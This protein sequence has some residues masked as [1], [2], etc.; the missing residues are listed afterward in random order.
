VPHSVAPGKQVS[1][2]TSIPEIWPDFSQRGK[3]ATI[4]DVLQHQAVNFPSGAELESS[5]A[6]ESTGNTWKY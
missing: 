4:G 3:T 5:Q 1:F 6:Q 2:N